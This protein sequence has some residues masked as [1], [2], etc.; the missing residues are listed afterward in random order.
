MPITRLFIVIL[1]IIEQFVEPNRRAIE[2][3]KEMITF[4]LCKSFF[5][6]YF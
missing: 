4:N 6:I 2:E 1:L 3:P 5:K